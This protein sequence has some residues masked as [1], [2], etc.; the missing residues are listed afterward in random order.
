MVFRITGEFRTR[1]S[2]GSRTSFNAL[3]NVV[4]EFI[5]VRFF[6]NDADLVLRPETAFHVIHFH[7]D[8]RTDLTLHHETRVIGKRRAR[9][10][11]VLRATRSIILFTAAR[12][13]D[14][15]RTLQHKLRLVKAKILH[16][17]RHVD[18][19]IDIV[20]RAGLRFGVPTAALARKRVGPQAVKARR[21]HIRHIGRDFRIV[22]RPE[23]HRVTAQ[24]IHVTLLH[25]HFT[26]FKINVV[27]VLFVTRRLH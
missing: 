18:W 3:Q 17:G 5:L 21:I 8:V 6:V 7:R 13:T 10:Q 24:R 20:K 14:V 15:H 12:K 9:E 26:I 1:Q 23:F 22:R 19:N 27:L 11:I 4:F 25:F 2:E 16:P